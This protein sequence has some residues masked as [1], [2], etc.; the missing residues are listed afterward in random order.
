MASPTFCFFH[1]PKELRLVVYECIPIATRH[2]VLQDPTVT[3]DI[4]SGG[5]T[6]TLVVKSL[7]IGMLLASSLTFDECKPIFDRK[8]KALRAEP[9]RLIVDSTSWD[10]MRA[11]PKTRE[12]NRWCTEDFMFHARHD[13]PHCWEGKKFKLARRV[14]T[15]NDPEFIHIVKFM[16]TITTIRKTRRPSSSMI[17]VRPKGAYNFT[18]DLADEIV[19]AAVRPMLNMLP[20][21]EWTLHASSPEVGK[22]GVNISDCVAQFFRER[23]RWS[24]PKTKFI[25]RVSPEEWAR[26]WEECE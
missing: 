25:G 9:L 1:L 6:I 5:S 12:T 3:D 4:P 14:F 21:P 15:P 19:R 8:L 2:H 7:S 16:G 10:A 22:D 24:W 17:A 20:A 11:H 23:N 13:R 26:D 18:S